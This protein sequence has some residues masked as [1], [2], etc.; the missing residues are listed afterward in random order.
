MKRRAFIALLG[1]GA[2]VAWPL[3][4]CAQQS[5]RVYRVGVLVPFPPSVIAPLFDELR[6]LGFVE[7]E[8]LAIDGR[9]FAATAEQ[10]PAIASDLVAAAPDAILC[11]GD[12]TIRAAQAATTTIPIV[13]GTDD[14]LGAGLVRSLAHPR[15]NTTGFSILATELDGK[16]QEILMELLPAARRMAALVD[17]TAV[18]ASHLEALREGARSRGV[19][20]S[21]HSVDRGEA[22]A[23]AIEAAKRAG[24]AALNVLASPLLHGNSG[25]IIEQTAALRLPAIY[26][27]PETAQQGG[28]LAYG[29]RLSE[30]MRQW[31]RQLARILH[32]A[33]PADM[34]V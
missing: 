33:K 32:G 8:N 11:A 15:G 14:M 28:L 6:R 19:E 22:V 13:A 27:W 16:R 10:F 34:P 5:G 1:G 26:Q 20:L 17:S 24:T 21:F 23:S 2:A 31:A 7:R 4:V 18:A 30:I 29:P 12:A 3:A 9:G 25:T